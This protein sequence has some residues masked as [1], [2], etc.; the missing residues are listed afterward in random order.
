MKLGLSY[1]LLVVSITDSILCNNSWSP[2]FSNHRTTYNDVSSRIV[3]IFP[4]V[5]TSMSYINMNSI[6]KYDDDHRV[7][8]ISTLRRSYYITFFKIGPKTNPCGTPHMYSGTFFLHNTASI[9]FP[10]CWVTSN[11]HTESLP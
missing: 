4:V 10:L 2:F 6:S 1:I 11:D 9:F 5:T 3:V 7:S 8:L